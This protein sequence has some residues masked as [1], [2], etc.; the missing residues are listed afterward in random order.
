MITLNEDFKKTPLIFMDL[1][2]GI[3][4]VFKRRTTEEFLFEAK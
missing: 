1:Q 3:L 4:G 2:K